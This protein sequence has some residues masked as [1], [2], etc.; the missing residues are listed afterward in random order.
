MS[1]WG[2]PR[3][4]PN[5]ALRLE[6][7]AVTLFERHGYAGVTVPQIAAE[8]GLT[9]RTFFRHFADKRD[10]MFLRDREF[11]RVVESAMAG[12]DPSV[13]PTE[14]ARRGLETA[15]REL[16]PLRERFLRRSR[17]IEADPPLQERELLSRK[18]LTDA[19]AQSLERRGTEPRAARLVAALTVTCFTLALE[20]WLTDDSARDLPAILGAVR[21]EMRHYLV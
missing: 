5:A 12:I 10:V 4:S 9:T 20:R 15:C 17:I 3:W 8:A 7:A 1:S 2:V 18:V 13:A 16:Q 11:P 21:D 6:E 19:V 14:A